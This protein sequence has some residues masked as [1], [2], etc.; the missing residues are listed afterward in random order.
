MVVREHIQ[1]SD[2]WPHWL[3]YPVLESHLWGP[4]C[5][6]TA[7]T[8]V[9]CDVGRNIAKKQLFEPQRS[10][11]RGESSCVIR[12]CLIQLSINP[13]TS[14][15]LSPESGTCPMPH[16]K[17]LPT[18][19]FYVDCPGT[20]ALVWFSK[21]L[22]QL[23]AVS[24]WMSISHLIGCFNRCC[25]NGNNDGHRC[26]TTQESYDISYRSFC[27][28]SKDMTA[29][30]LYLRCGAV[31]FA[32]VA[33]QRRWWLQMFQIYRNLLQSLLTCQFLVLIYISQPAWRVQKA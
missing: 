20:L 27:G 15:P 32:T 17:C 2:R 10:S 31:Q 11:S 3:V 7:Q 1:S 4:R 26:F 21:D 23:F 12:P 18:L 6:S 29:P 5:W 30:N 24:L 16:G 28:K 22:E 25:D 8:S 33:L 14:P 19:G 13:I 9:L